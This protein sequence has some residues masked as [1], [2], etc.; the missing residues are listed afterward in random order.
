MTTLEYLNRV[1]A[2]TETYE[3]RIKEIYEQ[4]L[5]EV[6]ETSEKADFD[7]NYFKFFLSYAEVGNFVS[8]LIGYYDGE[9]EGEGYLP[10]D[11]RSRF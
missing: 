2:E 10:E 1:K 11:E 3:Q 6:D 4:A 8:S 5:A 9:V 7:R